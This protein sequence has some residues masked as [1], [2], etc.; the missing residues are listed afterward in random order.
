MRCAG[1]RAY[2]AVL[3]GLL[4][5]VG[6]AG[7]PPRDAAPVETRR[8]EPAAAPA[9]AATVAPERVVPPPAPAPEIDEP[10]APEPG[11][12][13]EPGVAPVR[14]RAG[15]V[16]SLLAAA[17]AARTRGELDRAQAALERAL[18]LAPGD[19][20]IWYRLARV[21]YQQGDFDQAL[22]LARRTLSL[23]PPLAAASAAWRLIADSH[24]ALGADD[25][26]RAARRRAV[27]P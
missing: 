25:A 10:V 11:A 6:C 3:C 20:E 12:A 23:S 4:L 27:T 1:V 24:A 26:A 2:A 15:A 19:Y 21:H 22:Q 9:A 17:A 18:R 7:G 8:P 5:I 14:E 16:Q 13:P